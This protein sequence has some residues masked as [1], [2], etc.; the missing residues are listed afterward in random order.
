[1]DILVKVAAVLRFI[2][3]LYVVLTFWTMINKPVPKSQRVRL[4]WRGYLLG[5][6][7]SAAG[8]IMCG[9][10]FGWW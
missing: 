2:W 4:T 5:C 8:F 7:L 10:C 1:M 3:S 9:R 6:V